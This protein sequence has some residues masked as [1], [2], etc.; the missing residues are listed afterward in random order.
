MN[1][2]EASALVADY[3]YLIGQ[4]MTRLRGNET[5]A[6]ISTLLISPNKEKAEQVYLYWLYDETNDNARA[7]SKLGK[8]YKNF[9]VFVIGDD[10]ENIIPHELSEYLTAHQGV[11]QSAY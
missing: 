10:G 3:Q 2:Q 8:E 9:L 11:R 1:Y 4:R 6:T 5:A 7:I